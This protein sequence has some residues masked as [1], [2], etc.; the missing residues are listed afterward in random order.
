MLLGRNWNWLVNDQTEGGALRV[1]ERGGAPEPRSFKTPGAEAL[2]K[3]R[4]GPRGGGAAAV[5]RARVPCPAP[6]ASRGA[7]W[8]GARPVPPLQQRRTP[9]E[10][11]SFGEGAELRATKQAGSGQLPTADSESVLFVVSTNQRF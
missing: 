10:V 8:P 5:T 1:C 11:T 7:P 2:L 4:K 3:P 6:C 9:P